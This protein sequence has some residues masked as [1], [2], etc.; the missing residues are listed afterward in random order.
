MKKLRNNCLV[1]FKRAYRDFNKQ[2]TY[3]TYYTILETSIYKSKNPNLFTERKMAW[4]NFLKIK[5]IPNHLKNANDLN[6][7]FTQWSQKNN[8]PKYV[9]LIFYK[10][11]L[12][13]NDNFHFVQI[14]EDWVSKIILDIKTNAFGANN[15]IVF[16]CY[17]LYFRLLPI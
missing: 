2:E 10:N 6:V 9:L 15:T 8:T 14:D 13:V 11:N 12:F 4:L 1:C 3:Y 17:P 5:L 16:C 7:F